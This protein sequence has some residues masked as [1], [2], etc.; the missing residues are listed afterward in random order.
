MVRMGAQAIRLGLDPY[1][2]LDQ[3][4]EDYVI[5]VAMLNKALEIENEQLKLLAEAT[6]AYVGNRV[7]ELF[8]NLLR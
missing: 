5:R 1:V 2:F 4:K 6:G 3:E 7:A 8:S